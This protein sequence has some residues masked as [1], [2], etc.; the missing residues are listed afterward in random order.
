M[1]KRE[2]K[3]RRRT[4]KRKRRRCNVDRK[5]LSVLLTVLL[6]VFLFLLLPLLHKDRRRGMRVKRRGTEKEVCS[7]SEA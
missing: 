4:R 6:F 5:N 7:S 1:K 2:E 3:K